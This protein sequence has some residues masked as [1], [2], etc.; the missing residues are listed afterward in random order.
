M[1]RALLFSAAVGTSIT[2]YT[3]YAVFLRLVLERLI[4]YA[5]TG[6]LS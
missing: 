6:R 3:V 2:L 5:A 1:R 4:M